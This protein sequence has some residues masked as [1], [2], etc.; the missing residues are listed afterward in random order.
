MPICEGI[1][2]N[3]GMYVAVLSVLMKLFPP[4]PTSDPITTPME[5][6]RVIHILWMV[7]HYKLQKCSDFC[8]FFRGFFENTF[9]VLA[10]ICLLKDVVFQHAIMQSKF[11]TISTSTLEHQMHLHQY[12]YFF[13]CTH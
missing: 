8:K 12:E 13:L 9:T 10:M 2:D 1:G 5:P 3:R 7:L 6:S 4:N 11:F